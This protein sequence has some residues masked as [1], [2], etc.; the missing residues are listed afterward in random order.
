MKAIIIAVVLSVGLVVCVGCDSGEDP[1]SSGPG[2]REYVIASSDYLNNRFFYLDLPDFE[3]EG[4][5]PGDRIVLESLRVFMWLDIGAPQVGDLPNIAA[6]VD[7]LGC[8]RWDA[9][10]FSSPCLYGMWWRE[11]SWYPLVKVDSGEVYGVDLNR[12][13]GIGDA[14]A[15]IYEVRHEDG[16]ST[17]VGDRPD[18]GGPEQEISG[19]DGRYYRMKL[20]KAPVDFKELHSSAYVLRNIYSLGAV[21]IDPASFSLRIE[22][23]DS[24]N[25]Y[26]RQDETGSDYIRIFGLDRDDERF[27]GNPDGR[28][29]LNDPHLFDLRRGLLSFSREFP[30]PFA[31]GGQISSAGDAADQAAQAI[32]STYADTSAFVWN[33]SY[34][35]DHQ[36]W[37]FYDPE[38]FPAEYPDHAAFRII[39]TYPG[40]GSATD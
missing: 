37:Q 8:G 38:V 3:P 25:D 20:L 7:S 40:T 6:Y 26:P 13:F 36:S 5:Q 9:I 4:R 2:N 24:G 29:D 18:M 21:A 27:S 39:A 34:L 32:Y 12:E 30:H 16:T 31:P 28:V 10:D 22:S 23:L 17:R 19:E 14:L 35:R 1:T 33:P 15:V 11:V